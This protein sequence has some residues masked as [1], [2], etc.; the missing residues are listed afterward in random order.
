MEKEYF[1]RRNLEGLGILILFLVL[2]L[3]LFAQSIEMKKELKPSELIELEEKDCKSECLNDQKPCIEKCLKEKIEKKL[4]EV[5]KI[6]PD[7]MPKIRPL[8]SLRPFKVLSPLNWCIE[9]YIN[10]GHPPEEAKKFCALPKPEVPKPEVSKPEVPKPEILKPEV[11][12]GIKNPCDELNILIFAYQEMIKK[13][14]E[15]EELAKKD[16]AKITV[17][18]DLKREIEFLK[19]RIDQMNFACSQGKP[20]LEHSCLRLSELETIYIPLADKF[21]TFKEKGQILDFE[22][23]EIDKIVE[24]IIVLKE[25]CRK[26][27]L[28]TEKPESLLEIEKIYETKIKEIKEKEGILQEVIK[29]ENIEEEEEEEEEIRKT[30]EE[31]KEILEDFLKRIKELDLKKTKLIKK[32]KISKKEILI[33]ETKIP[34]IP[35]EL[36]I[37]EKAL[38][39]VPSLKGLVIEDRGVKTEGNVEL[40]FEEGNLVGVKSKKP[41]K[42]LPSEAIEKIKE[43]IKEIKEINFKEDEKNLKYIIKTEKRGKLFWLIPVNFPINYEVDTET[44]KFKIKKPWWKF[45]VRMK[46]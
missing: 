32:M 39:I 18:E 15:L 27:S 42:I 46:K 45:L 34:A 10:L 12:P 1:L 17:L 2:P 16:Q 43:E 20:A 38:R 19:K 14:T 6:K 7:E 9:K 3:F 29:E 35:I 28:R 4:G 22:E 26:T 37:K 44:G 23:K 36:E 30:E 21:L 25:K 11:T 8:K 41:I 33:E 5:P 40:E 31:K 13:E 24:E